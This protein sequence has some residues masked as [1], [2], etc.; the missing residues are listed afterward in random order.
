MAGPADQQFG[1]TRRLKAS[2]IAKTFFSC[3]MPP[4]LMILGWNISTARVSIS[5]V[6]LRA[7]YSSSPVDSGTFNLA[8]T[9][10]NPA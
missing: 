5:L 8:L 9:S 2:A 1:A 6:K 10:A 3:R 4:I 7:V